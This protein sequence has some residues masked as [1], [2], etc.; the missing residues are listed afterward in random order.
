MPVYYPSARVRLKVRLDEFGPYQ[1]LKALEKKPED[2][3]ANVGGSGKSIAQ[4][5]RE[6]YAKQAELEK[7]RKRLSPQ[8]FRR[9]ARELDAE[10][11]AIDSDANNF[12]LAEAIKGGEV[13]PNVVEINVLPLDVSIRRNNILDADTCSLTFDYRDLP[14]DPRAVR[15]VFV[16]AT[17]GA[18]TEIEHAEG[19]EGSRRDD[20]S[21][22]SLADR[23]EVNGQQFVGFAD[24]WQIEHSDEGSTVHL[25]CRDL[26]AILRGVRLPPGQSIDL[27]K[28]LAV[29]VQDLINKVGG[30]KGLKVFYGP[31][32]QEEPNESSPVPGKAVSKRKFANKG[33]KLAQARKAKNETLYDHIIAA[34]GRV[35]HLPVFRG[36]SL[37]LVRPRGLTTLGIRQPLVR[38]MVWGRNI[39]NLKFARKL[40]GVQVPT[41]QVNSFDPSI[42]RTRWARFG[43][44]YRDV[45]GGIIGDPDS[46]QPEN[47]RPAVVG[48]GGAPNESVRVMSVAGVSDLAE[49][50]E[51][52]R[53]TYEQIG[54]QEIEG[55]FETHDLES[56][57]RPF[58]LDLLRIQS[59]DP[60]TI[61]VA[62]ES[63][64]EPTGED[65]G[66]VQPSSSVL[67]ELSAQN[68]ERRQSYLRGLGYSAE[69][70]KRIATVQE[71]LTLANTFRASYVNF[72]WS[73]EDGLKIECTVQNYI[74]LREDEDEDDEIAEIAAAIDEI[75]ED[76]TPL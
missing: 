29:G 67:Q 30:A 7:R 43:R 50:K 26:S 34:A 22:I 66:S 40:G 54:R 53:S 13:D 27:T 45:P 8:E 69:N 71:K 61:L 39:A 18:V 4:R 25:D 70:S 11:D 23:V 56:F 74:A 73:H 15:A 37:Y 17:I 51:I 46:P 47:T 6:L 5:R 35:G 14:L 24:E 9:Q 33:K 52:A 16:E 55:T 32:G 64:Q 65:A 60:V 76:V 3:P 12:D 42:G 49:L 57:G 59:G 44:G 21:L 58:E 1:G 19:I 62:P 28:P 75:G 38:R 68:V 63:D 2:N 10:L 36:F 72:D 20:G 31:P 48:P 41:I